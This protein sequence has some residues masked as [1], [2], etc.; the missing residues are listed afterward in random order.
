MDLTTILSQIDAQITA[1]QQAKTLLTDASTSRKVGRPAKATSPVANPT[2][3]PL[4]AEAKARIV[5]AQK[6]RWAKAKKA[7]PAKTV[8]AKTA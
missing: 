8:S 4:S 6:K 5:A 1:L 3:M 2:R 7:T